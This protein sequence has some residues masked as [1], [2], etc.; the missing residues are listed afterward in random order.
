MLSRA[1]DDRAAGV[2]HGLAQVLA[3]GEVADLDGEELGALLVD[4]I[5]EIAVVRAV[6]G[7][8]ELP[9][10]LALGLLVAVEQDLS[11]RRRRVAAGTGADTGRR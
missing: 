11:R 7:G 4:R 3:G 5:G 9:V 1:P 6:R 2:G 10:A 8:T